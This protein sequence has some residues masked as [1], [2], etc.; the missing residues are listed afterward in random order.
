MAVAGEATVWWLGD[1]RHRCRRDRRV[2]KARVG[3]GRLLR[4]RERLSE[5]A[6]TRMWNDA[7]DGDPTGELLA[8]WIAKE[9]LRALLATARTGGQRHDVAHRLHRFYGW[10]ATVDV[11]E[12][13]TLALTV[14]AWWP[15][16]L[17]FLRTGVTNAGTEATNR[18]VKDAARVAFGFR[19]LDHQRRRVRFHCTRRQRTASASAR[20]LPP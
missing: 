13:T 8:A 1:S 9:E 16:I 19:N 17:A 12:I 20:A 5:R 18:Q 15:Q 7:V 3:A 11:P 14:Q 4:A 10:C 6:F 2:T